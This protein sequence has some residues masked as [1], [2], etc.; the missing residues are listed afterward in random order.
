MASARELLAVALKNEPL[1]LEDLLLSCGAPYL[2]R[3][4]LQIATATLTADASEV[5]ALKLQADIYT[6]LLSKV[7]PDLK[8]I[9]HS[10]EITERQ[11]VVSDKPMSEKD[12]QEQH[13]AAVEDRSRLQ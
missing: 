4:L 6:R 9:E 3:R 10:G 8:A 5:P 2:K 7:E 13:G 11:Y 1:A 12:W